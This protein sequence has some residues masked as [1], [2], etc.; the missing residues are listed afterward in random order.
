MASSLAAPHI[1]GKSAKFTRGVRRFALCAANHIIVLCVQSVAHKNVKQQST[2]K[3]I[4]KKKGMGAVPTPKGY[5]RSLTSVLAASQSLAQDEER[6]AGEGREE[7]IREEVGH[8]H[9]GLCKGCEDERRLRTPFYILQCG[10]RRETKGTHHLQRV[11][12]LCTDV[13]TDVLYVHMVDALT[14]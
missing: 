3:H 9:E 6:L 11:W 1:M 10:W 2:L 5:I 14:E 12:L 7:A 13:S 4:S 8:I